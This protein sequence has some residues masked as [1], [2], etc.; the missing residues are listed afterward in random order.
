MLNTQIY[1][2]LN[3]YIPGMSCAIWVLKN[4]IVNYYWC[5]SFGYVILYVFIY[6][7]LNY[8]L[9]EKNTKPFYVI[10]IQKKLTHFLFNPHNSSVNHENLFRFY[11]RDSFTAGLNLLWNENK[12]KMF[13]KNTFRFIEFW[14]ICMLWQHFF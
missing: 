4:Y 12:L 2:G 5:F 11:E 13:F 9:D 6:Y 14:L 8:T 3:S 1:S 10:C 7:I